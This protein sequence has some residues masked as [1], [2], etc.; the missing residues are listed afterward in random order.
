MSELPRRPS[1]IAGSLFPAV[2][3]GVVLFVFTA[4][5]PTRLRADEP[6]TAQPAPAGK[7]YKVLVRRN[8]T[9][10]APAKGE[11]LPIGNRLDVYVPEGPRNFPVLLLVH[12]GAWIGGDK[13]LDRIPEV[14]DCF[15]RQGIGVVAPNYRLSPFFQHPAHVTDV[16]KALAWTKKNISGYGG[17]LDRI[18]LLGHSAGGHLVSLLASDASYLEKEGLTRRDVQGVISVSGVYQVSDVT[19]DHLMKNSAVKVDVSLKANPFTLVFGKD[20]AVRRQASPLTHVQPG[21]PPFLIVYAAD[22][23]PT[24][25]DMAEKFSAA[26]QAKKCEVRLCKVAERNHLTVFR[27]ARRADDPVTLAVLEFMQKHARR[28]KP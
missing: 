4:L 7:P 10:R 25:G 26:L 9:Y 21:L 2:P 17:D 28:P 8:I 22:D 1:S 12:G 23:L 16:A 20:E 14:A 13:I 18:F 5:T 11:L 15:A 19:L 6:A 3:F 24:L 27:N